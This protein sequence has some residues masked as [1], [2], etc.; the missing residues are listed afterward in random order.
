M[1]TQV[2]ILAIRRTAW[3]SSRARSAASRGV[4]ISMNISSMEY[5]STRGTRAAR[6]MY[7]RR[8]MSP[9]MWNGVSS[10]LVLRIGGPVAAGPKMQFSE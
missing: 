7:M 10:G 1:P 5:G 9:F 3:R 6:T 4:S 2:G 8:L